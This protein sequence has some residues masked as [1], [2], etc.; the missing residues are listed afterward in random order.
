MKNLF[1]LIF[2]LLSACSQKIDKKAS[3]Q[4]KY[5]KDL[6]GCF[7]LYDMKAKDFIKIVGEENCEERLP[8]C[9]TFKVPLAVMAFDSGVLKDEKQVLKWDG[10][11]NIRP[12]VNQDHNAKTWMRDSVVWFSQRIT[13]KLGQK[14]FQKYLDNF[15]YGNKNIAAG[16]KT[17][18]ITSPSKENALKI[19]AFEQVEFMKKLWTSTL[20]AS[21]RS[22]RLAREITFLEKSPSGYEFSGKTGSNYY[23]KEKKVRLGWFISHLQRGDEEYIAVTNISDRGPYQGSEYGGMRAKG[24]TKQILLD[25]GIW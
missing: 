3:D 18:W 20:P 22:M 12:E 17:A 7:L 10:V 15:E 14:K 21:Q 11:K 2:F 19:S 6:K 16:I 13:P 8:P 1:V 25:E 5:F 23:D 9:S 24:I 4:D